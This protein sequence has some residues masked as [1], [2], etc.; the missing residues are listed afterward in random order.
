VAGRRGVY[1]FED[2]P[3]PHVAPLTFVGGTGRSGT[4]IVSRFLGK[5]GRLASIPLECLFH[6]ADDGFPGLLAGTTT[7]AAFLKKLSGFWWHGKQRG[8]TRGLHRIVPREVFDYSVAEFDRDFES[9]PEFACRALFFNLLWPWA[10]KRGA[11]GLVEQSCDVIAAAPTLIKLFPEARWV[12]SVRDGRDTSASRV[13]Q[14]RGLVYP[15]TRRQ[16]IRWWES[17]I[18]AIHE[19]SQVIPEDR[20]AEVGL[21]ELLGE[22]ARSNAARLA[23]FVNVRMGKRMRRFFH[24]QISVDAAH[25]HRWM[26]G[27]SARRQARYNRLYL[28]AL[29]RLEADGVTCVAIL[30]RTYDGRADETGL[31][32]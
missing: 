5:H 18:R 10:V 4:H 12:H 9:D 7:K 3:H 1:S 13:S 31:A 8:R 25:T 30:R 14:T 28:G 2:R 27:L 26:V 16:G 17:R 15:R 6:V 11:S 29:D 21:E 23:K 20:L 22:N 32:S 19:G 24:G